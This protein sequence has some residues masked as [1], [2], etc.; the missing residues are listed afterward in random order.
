MDGLV[1][2][3][4]VLLI[5]LDLFRAFAVTCWVISGSPDLAWP[6]WHGWLNGGAG[7]A[8]AW[9]MRYTSHCRLPWTEWHSKLEFQEREK[10]D[11]QNLGRVKYFM[12]HILSLKQSPSTLSQEYRKVLCV[13]TRGAVKSHYKGSGCGGLGDFVLFLLS[14][15][16]ALI[17][18]MLALERNFTRTTSSVEELKVLTLIL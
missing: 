16:S 2:W 8:C 7:C 13:L 5:S 14:I 4:L 9:T 10:R 15:C 18:F 1:D 17:Y 12:H 11:V 3:G 6:P